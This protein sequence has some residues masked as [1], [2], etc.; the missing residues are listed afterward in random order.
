M[1]EVSKGRLALFTAVGILM[2]MVVV[3]VAQYLVSGNISTGIMVAI[4]TP[5]GLLLGQSLARGKTK[6]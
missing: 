3:A 5:T 2:M 4:A 1:S 6:I